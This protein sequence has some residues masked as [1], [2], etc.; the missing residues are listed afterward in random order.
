MLWEE[1]ETPLQ[2]QESPLTY[3][4]ALPNKL[5]T[6][7]QLVKEKL[8]KA[9]EGQSCRY[10]EGMCPRE[11]TPGQQVLLLLPNSENKLLMGWQGS[12]E[13]IQKVGGQLPNPC[14]HQGFTTV[15]C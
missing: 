11:F 12:F 10:N 6:M 13:V 9:Q 7:S 4:A 3:L 15:S 1:W 2:S 14:P 5:K 8:L